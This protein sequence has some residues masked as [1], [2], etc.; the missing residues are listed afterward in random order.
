[1]VNTR[2]RR[3]DPREETTRG[4]ALMRNLPLNCGLKDEKES[5]SHRREGG[6]LSRLKQ[7]QVQRP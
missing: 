4:P 3:H 7:E 1:M 2:K 6:K 5:A